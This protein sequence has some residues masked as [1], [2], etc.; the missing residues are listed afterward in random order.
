MNRATKILPV[1]PLKLPKRR[2]KYGVSAPAE[3]TFD[4][5]IYASK[6]EMARAKQWNKD[7]FYAVFEQVRVSLG[8]R[9]N[10]YVV[11]FLVFA[12]NPRDASV[13]S[14]TFWAEDVKGMKTAK[15][16]RDIKLWARYGPCPLHILTRS[17][18]GWNA[19]VITPNQE[20]P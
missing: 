18:D 9:E 10:V 4:G 3:R 14:G 16:A 17:G 12:R 11:D 13:N 7:P 6:A 15:F 5:K 1:G 2:N 19:E 8:V 20:G